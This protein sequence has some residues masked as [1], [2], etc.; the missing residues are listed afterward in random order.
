MS[1]ETPLLPLSARPTHEHAIFLRVCH[2]PWTFIGQ[3]GLTTYRGIILAFLLSVFFTT[4]DYDIRIA[5]RGTYFPFYAGHITVGVQILYYT[6]TTVSFRL[7]ARGKQQWLMVRLD[8]VRSTH[9][10]PT[11]PST[12]GRGWKRLRSQQSSQ[13]RR[14]LLLDSQD[15]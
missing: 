15:Q 14:F 10:V 3:K 11:Q 2:S 9:P 13:S 8:V 5:G 7:Q 1:E 6:I 4:L 12:Q